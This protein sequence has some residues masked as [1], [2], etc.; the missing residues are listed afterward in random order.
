MSGSMLA[1]VYHWD[2]GFQVQAVARPRPAPGE[3]LI[4]VD[5]CGICASDVNEALS[6]RR[7]QSADA[8]I[9]GHEFSGIVAELGAGVCTLQLGDRVVVDPVWSCGA[10]C[11]CRRAQPQHCQHKQTLG[12]SRPG[13]FAQFVAAPAACAYPLPADL[14]LETAALAEPLACALHAVELSGVRTGDRAVVL[15]TGNI[16]LL[17]VQL[18]RMHGAAVLGID[19]QPWRLEIALAMGAS[20]VVNASEVDVV[21]AARAWSDGQGVDVVIESAGHAATGAQAMSMGAPGSTVV[22]FGVAATD[23]ALAVPQQ[24]FVLGGRQ[25]L[26]CVGTPFLFARALALLA[27]RN[28][29]V[30]PL[31]THRLGLDDL[32][33]AIDLLA[34][35]QGGALKVLIRPQNP[36][37]T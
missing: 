25:L 9:L 37:A 17:M 34:H 21:E 23:E 15:G 36:A 4:Q 20:A 7:Q 13:A 11:Q 31:I 2:T 29:C 26:G 1:A 24:S 10:C 32:G 35:Q 33:S 3:V 22:L 14:S 12:F 28:V 27:A 19:V 16:G 8:R 30:E 18:L 5:S 6:L